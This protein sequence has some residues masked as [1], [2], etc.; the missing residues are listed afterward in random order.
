MKSPDKSFITTESWDEASLRGIIE[1]ASRMKQDPHSKEWNT[2]LKHKKFLM[3]FHNPSLRTHLSFETAVTDLGGSAIYYGPGM[4]W[5]R[6]EGGV[7]SSES[8]KD[9]AKVVSRY[10][11][12]VG[13]RISMDAVPQYG[14]GYRYLSDFASYAEVPVVSMAGDRF[15]P[16]QAM[17]DLMGWAER[18][19]HKNIVSDINKLRGKTLLLT[20]GSSGFARPWASVQSHLLLAARFGMN[21]KLAH[22]EG[23]ALDPEVTDK[24]QVYCAQNNTSFQ[25]IHD[26]SKGYEGADVVYVRNWISNDAYQNGTFQYQSEIEKAAMLKDWIV[27]TQKMERTNKAIFA[28]PMPVD[29]GKEVEDSVADSDYS[30]IYDVAENRLHIQKALLFL[31]MGNRVHL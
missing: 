27:T 6:T 26:A 10:V 30:V 5:S 29:R 14:D 25:L 13:I 23:Y 12:G 9:I 15:H 18:F 19:T 31:L 11:D 28:N 7:A 16:C 17:A 20:W 8:L 4:G 2:G 1:L 21:I 22:P 24:A 3:M